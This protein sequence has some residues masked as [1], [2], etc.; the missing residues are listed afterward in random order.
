MNKQKAVVIMI[1]WWLDLLL[2]IITDV[3]SSNPAK[4]RYARYNI[5]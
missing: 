3:V 2:P 5:I 1:I 4:A